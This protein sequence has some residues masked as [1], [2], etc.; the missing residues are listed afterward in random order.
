MTILEIILAVVVSAVTGAIASLI[1]PWAN[2]G[3]EKR[4]KKLEWRKGFIQD[5]KRRIGED[6][7]NPDMFRETSY[8]SNLKLHLSK[9]L[10]REVERKRYTPGTFLDADKR[11]EITMAEFK[12]KKD[13]LDEIALLEKK[14]GLL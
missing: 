1:A 5:C 14:W 2:W 8:Y 6:K 3:V 9:E 7:F 11:A 12:V 10:Q 13:L 4:K